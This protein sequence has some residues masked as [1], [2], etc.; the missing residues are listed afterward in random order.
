MAVT[1]CDHYHVIHY[2]DVRR[3]SPAHR[4]FVQNHYQAHNKENINV[5]AGVIDDYLWRNHRWYVDSSNTQN[6]SMSWRNHAL[7][8]FPRE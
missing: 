5:I 7:H 1:E 4:L 2:G 6:V 3:K 8:A